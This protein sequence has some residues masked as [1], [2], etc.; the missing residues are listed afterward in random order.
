MPNVSDAGFADQSE[1]DA[2]DIAIL[3][4][5]YAMTGVVSGCA[6]TA[7]TSP[8]M[9]VAVAVGVVS[10]AGI[11]AAVAA[12][13]V[14]I[15]AAHATAP[16]KDIV[17]VGSTGT[18]AVVAGTAAVQLLKPA[19]PASSVV[20]AEVYVP[21]ADTAIASNQITDKRVVLEVSPVVATASLPAASAA[22]DGRILIEDAG[23]GNRNLIVY[24]GAQ[25]FRI[26][27]GANV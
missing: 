14:T 21:A 16:R 20:L 1:P 23:A 26:D 27:G 9:T 3:V 10:V 15:G 18:K 24:A 13:N 7:Q 22:M 2:T 17:V 6:V 19:I 11:N 12:G 25:R 8:D 5:G 4:S